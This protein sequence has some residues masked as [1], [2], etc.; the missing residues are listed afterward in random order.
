MRAAVNRN[1]FSSH[2]RTFST[3]QIGSKISSDSTSSV[4]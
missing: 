4:T 1:A 3:K 2:Q